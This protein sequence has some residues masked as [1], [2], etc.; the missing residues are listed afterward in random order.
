MVNLTILLAAIVGLLL[1]P[2]FTPHNLHTI[3]V[4]GAS[5]PTVHNRFPSMDH[6]NL[7]PGGEVAGMASELDA[8]ASTSFH[9]RGDLLYP[10]NFSGHTFDGYFGITQ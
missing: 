3:P 1:A 10:A 8:G 6:F 7:M 2:A 4:G 9:P 5:E